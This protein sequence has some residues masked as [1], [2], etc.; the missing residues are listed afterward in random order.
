V[1]RTHEIPPGGHAYIPQHFMLGFA[2]ALFHD[3]GFIPSI[4]ETG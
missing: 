3:V 2:A 4:S 1:I